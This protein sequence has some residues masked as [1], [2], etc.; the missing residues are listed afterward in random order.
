MK[1][2]MIELDDD[3]AER[4]E[5]VAPARSRKRSEFVRAAIRRAIWDL[6][7]QAIEASYRAQPDDEPIYFAPELWEV[8][9]PAPKARKP[10]RSR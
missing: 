3:T 10:K 4:L 9:E 8:R 1:Q 6:E 2:V 5:A 7:E